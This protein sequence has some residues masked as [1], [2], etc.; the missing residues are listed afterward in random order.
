MTP[1]LVGLLAA[2]AVAA[3]ATRPLWWRAPRSP[4]L[5][6]AV[7]GFVAAVSIGGHL[8]LDAAPQAEAAADREVAALVDGLAQQLQAHPDDATLLADYAFALTVLRGTGFGG[9][10]TRLVERAL[11]L[12]P[13]NRKALALA[14]TIAFERGDHAA[15]LRHWEILARH[16]PVNSPLL[17]RVRGHIETAR[18]LAR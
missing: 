11:R 16:E 8:V 7:A 5:A 1:V 2:L 14:G 10:P 15:A 12:D 9:E 3:A 18:R 13:L 6:A 17:A 4:W